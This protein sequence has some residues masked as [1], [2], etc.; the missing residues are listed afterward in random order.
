MKYANTYCPKCRTPEMAAERAK[1]L[2]PLDSDPAKAELLSHRIAEALATSGWATADEFLLAAAH[3]EIEELNTRFLGE[4]CDAAVD[5]CL[6]FERSNNMSEHFGS[7]DSAAQSWQNVGKVTI[8]AA[9]LLDEVENVF[10]QQMVAERKWGARAAVDGEF[11]QE[12]VDNIHETIW[13][14]LEDLLPWSEPEDRA[15]AVLRHARW[16]FG[17][18][19]ASPGEVL[20]AMTSESR[21]SETDAVVSAIRALLDGADWERTEALRK[22]AHVVRI[23][24]LDAEGF[25]VCNECRAAA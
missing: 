22:A 4:P 18:A 9:Y 24:V 12:A 5:P 20:R 13:E 25:V 17:D 2:V 10:A 7:W 1:L 23:F 21:V 15:E 11:D 14:A 8:A 19:K 16:V 3:G 6:R